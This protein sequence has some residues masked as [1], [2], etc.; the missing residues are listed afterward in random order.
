[1]R[2]TIWI[3]FWPLKQF[4]RFSHRVILIQR[5][6]YA[7]KCEYIHI[8]EQRSDLLK[9]APGKV[10]NLDPSSTSTPSSTSSST[11]TSH[12]P[13]LSGESY[14]LSPIVPFV[15]ISTLD[16]QTKWWE[17]KWKWMKTAKEYVTTNIFWWRWWW[18]CLIRFVELSYLEKRPCEGLVAGKKKTSIIRILAAHDLF[19]YSQ[20]WK[21]QCTMEVINVEEMNKKNLAPHDLF[22]ISKVKATVQD[23][24]NQCGIYELLVKSWSCVL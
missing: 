17:I 24:G 6:R 23:G 15:T 7:Q 19:W 8:Y 21:S 10:S 12:Q 9:L 20:K 1:M 5:R 4:I 14:C 2:G 22:C 11:S 18:L 16:I 13:F 3:L